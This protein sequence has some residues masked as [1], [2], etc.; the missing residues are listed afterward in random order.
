MAM[1][2]EEI[3]HGRGDHFRRGPRRSL[4]ARRID[5]VRDPVPWHTVG[6]FLIARLRTELIHNKQHFASCLACSQ[7]GSYP[8]DNS[9]A[10]RG[11][12]RETH[13]TYFTTERVYCNQHLCFE[14][15]V[16][17]SIVTL[18]TYRCSF[19]GRNAE[20]HGKRQ[21]SRNCGLVRCTAHVASGSCLVGIVRRRGA[22]EGLYQTES[23]E[24]LE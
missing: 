4:G 13:H 22:H 17:C 20:A 18:A 14:L 24:G 6:T 23:A 11:R 21:N 5:Q 2:F 7:R 12:D 15:S 19:C 1:R 16:E 8:D 3:K 9:M 10:P